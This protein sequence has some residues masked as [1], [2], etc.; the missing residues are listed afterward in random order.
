MSG[1]CQRIK[2]VDQEQ[3]KG[4][5]FRL[6]STRD[7]ARAVAAESDPY[8]YEAYV[9]SHDI[10]VERG[11]CLFSLNQNKTEARLQRG[12]INITSSNFAVLVRGFAP[13]NKTSQFS[14]QTVLPYI[15]GCSTKQI[16]APD[17]PGDPTLQ[18]L[19]IPPSTT[20]QH[21]H[22]HSTARCVYVLSGSGVCVL[23]MG[24]QHRIPLEAGMMCV[25]D[26]MS[27]HH[28]ETQKEPLWVLPVH[29]WS[30]SEAE[31]HHPM[32]QGT[33]RI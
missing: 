30:S 21:H 28:F 24:N 10:K 26:P 18:L 4:L 19:F 14:R 16:F 6:F 17:R 13:D 8:Y 5:G 23:G 33:F 2:M 25:F 1:A 32:Y 31:H 29:V 12:P 20:E 9:G 7:N 15:N 22:I 3:F 27:P 11:D